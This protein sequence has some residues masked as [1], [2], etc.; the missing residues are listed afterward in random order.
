MA[1]INTWKNLRYFKPTSKYDNWGDPVAIDETLLH[2]LDNFRHFIGHPVYVT[3]GV[4]NNESSKRSYHH[5]VKGA[6]AVD[7][8][9]PDYEKTAFD[10]VLDAMRF[11]FNGVG[12]YPHWKWQGNVVGGLHLDTRKTVNDRSAQWMGVLSP[13]KKQVY[14]GLSFLNLMKYAIDD[15]SVQGLH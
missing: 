12:F 14:I 10:L 8:V 6:C 15:V 13:E 3:S 4:R 5:P 9:I 2:R 11:G 7:V 1:K